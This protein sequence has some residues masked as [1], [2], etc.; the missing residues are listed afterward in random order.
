M[1]IKTRR[2]YSEVY[3]VLML[4]GNEY[5]DKLPSKLLTTIEEKRD[6][7]YNPIFK[8]NIALNQQNIKKEALSIIALMQLNYWCE[9]DAEKEELKETFRK[10]EEAHQAELRNKYNPNNIFKKEEKNAKDINRTEQT[11]L[12]KYEETFLKKFISKLKTLFKFK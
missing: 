8:D 6:I 10:N 11:E 9:S 1:N 4:L 2:I 5:T 7:N 3:Q 12:I